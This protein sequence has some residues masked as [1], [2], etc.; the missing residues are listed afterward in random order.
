MHFSCGPMMVVDLPSI[1]VFS[2]SSNSIGGISVTSIRLFYQN[3]DAV[4]TFAR[5]DV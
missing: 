5:D 3:S 1:K 4:V 2:A